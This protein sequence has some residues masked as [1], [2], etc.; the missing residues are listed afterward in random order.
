MKVKLDHDDSFEVIDGDNNTRYENS[1][2]DNDDGTDEYD[3]TVDNVTDDDG[4]VKPVDKGNGLEVSLEQKAEAGAGKQGGAHEKAVEN[5]T[6]DKE[7][8]L[9]GWLHHL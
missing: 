3:V 1:V 4:K 6:K 5:V 2:D 9:H 8:L 7:V